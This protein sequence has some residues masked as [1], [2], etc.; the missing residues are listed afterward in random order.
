[1]LLTI[2]AT[3]LA[4]ASP[5]SGAQLVPLGVQA[6]AQQSGQPIPSYEETLARIGE[7]DA[8]LFWSF[9]EGCDP[10]AAATLLHPDFRMLHDRGGLVVSSGEQMIEQSRRQCAARAPGGE[11]EGYRNRRMFVPGS[12]KVQLLGSWGA[13][14]EG[15]HTFLEWRGEERGWVQ[16]GGARYINTWQWMPGEAQF[17]LLESISVDHGAPPPY[18]PEG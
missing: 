3:L 5:A 4:A 10:D 7:N 16:T 18:P 6:P 8:R 14:E 17:R 9:F 2:A 13:L 15:Y 1:M 12:R 11:N